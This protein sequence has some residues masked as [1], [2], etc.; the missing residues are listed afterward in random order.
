MT[1]SAKH[2]YKSGPDRKPP[3]VHHHHPPIW[4][5]LSL[6]FLWSGYCQLCTFHAY[7]RN[8]VDWSTG[9]FSKA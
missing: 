3:G 1:P 6:A 7:C 2:C 9:E 4:I 8:N 5:C